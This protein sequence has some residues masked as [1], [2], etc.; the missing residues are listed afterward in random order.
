MTSFTRDAGALQHLRDQLGLKIEGKVNGWPV[1]DSKPRGPP[2]A[3]YYINFQDPAGEPTQSPL[4][5]DGHEWLKVGWEGYDVKRGYGWVG[6]YIG[7]ATIMKTTYLATG[8]NP[9]QR[10]I[11]YTTTAAPI[12]LTGISKTAN[13]R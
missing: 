11:I 12:P 9:L 10:S 8:P 6:P 4:S 2:R 13:T 7:N 5:V 3:A 1:L